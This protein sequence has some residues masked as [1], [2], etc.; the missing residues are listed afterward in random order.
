[1]AEPVLSEVEG[2]L[3][4]RP[5]GTGMPYRLTRMRAGDSAPRDAG[6]PVLDRKGNLATAALV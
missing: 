1:M 4:Q 3:A 5:L 2:L 6:F